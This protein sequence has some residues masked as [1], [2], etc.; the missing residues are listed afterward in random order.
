MNRSPSLAANPLVSSWLAVQ[1]DGTVI[2]MVGKVEL[3]QGIHTALTQIAIRELGLPPGKLVVAP[4]STAGSP[5]EGFTA[6]SL[7]SFR[8]PAPRS[9]RPAPPRGACFIEGAAAKADP[10]PDPS[11]SSTGTSARRKARSSAPTA[12]S[13][14]R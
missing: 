5:D 4:P 7:P 14:A 12:R 13:R 1:E 2:L 8:S 9:G 6:G 10:P 3:G 11:A